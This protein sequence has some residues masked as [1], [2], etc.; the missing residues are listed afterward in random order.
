MDTRTPNGKT[1]I[2]ITF[3]EY[4]KAVVDLQETQNFN[5][6]ILRITK[7][8]KINGSLSRYTIEYGW[9]R[10]SKFSTLSLSTLSHL[11]TKFE[12][13]RCARIE[14]NHTQRVLK[15]DGIQDYRYV[16]EIYGSGFYYFI[17]TKTTCGRTLGRSSDCNKDTQLADTNLKNQ[18]MNYKEGYALTMPA[19]ER[20]Q[21]LEEKRIKDAAELTAFRKQ[22]NEEAAAR[23]R[24][25]A[26]RKAAEQAAKENAEN[27]GCTELLRKRGYTIQDPIGGGR[28]TRG[29]KTRLRRLRK[30]RS[31]V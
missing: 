3:G 5:Y 4:D 14:L 30:T 22:G 20:D 26:E 27:K 8:E 2:K 1:E 29:R 28:R 31:R 23:E 15:Q 7:R 10:P 24:A 19:E 25:A 18:I 16:T 9:I 21:L 6:H 13:V 12:Y 11:N 17:D